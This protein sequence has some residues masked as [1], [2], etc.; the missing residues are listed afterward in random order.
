MRAADATDERHTFVFLPPAS[1]TT[2]RP[3]RGLRN[4]FFEPLGDGSPSATK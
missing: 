3:V 1:T 4:A 2:I